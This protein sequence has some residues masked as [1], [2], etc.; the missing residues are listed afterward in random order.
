MEPARNGG[1]GNRPG[2]RQDFGGDPM[3]YSVAWAWLF[4]AREAPA[5]GCSGLVLVPLLLNAPQA[6]AP[7]DRPPIEQV[8]R[9]LREKYKDNEKKHTALVAKVDKAVRKALAST[10][11]PGSATDSPRFLDTHPY[12]S[13]V[14]ELSTAGRTKP[15]KTAVPASY[16][17]LA[18]HPCCARL[19]LVEGLEYGSDRQVP[20]HENG[21]IELGDLPEVGPGFPDACVNQYLFG[22]QEIVGWRSCVVET[23]KQVSF[24]G[25]TPK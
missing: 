22:L 20:P 9:Q 14:N 11:F 2:I 8:L 23:K 16:D 21:F 10:P 19:D 5:L 15:A 13:L 24:R 25:L 4:V 12:L 1:P 7:P 17:I 6:P 3:R 18:R